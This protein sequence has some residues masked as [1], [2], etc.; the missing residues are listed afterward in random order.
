MTGKED[1]ERIIELLEEIVDLMTHVG[2]VFDRLGHEMPKTKWHECDRD[3]NLM[4]NKGE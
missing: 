4:H 3:K 1:R 2:A